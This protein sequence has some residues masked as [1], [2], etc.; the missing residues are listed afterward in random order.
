M[1]FPRSAWSGTEMVSPMRSGFQKANERIVG[2]LYLFA[3][4][5]VHAGG[6]RASMACIA[7]TI[8]SSRHLRPQSERR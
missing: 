6:M 2:T 8:R 1:A 4:S 5:V 3:Q 7:S